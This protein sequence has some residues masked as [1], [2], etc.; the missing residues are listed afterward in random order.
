MVLLCFRLKMLKT[1][2]FIVFSI[3][4]VE[5]HSHATMLN[6]PR[7]VVSFLMKVERHESQ[8]LAL[9]QVA[10]SSCSGVGRAR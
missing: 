8:G 1:S 5:K 7:D 4:N 3:K 2:S 9:R 10:S 6:T